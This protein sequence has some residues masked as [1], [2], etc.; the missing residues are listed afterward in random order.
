MQLQREAEWKRSRG[1]RQTIKRCTN[2]WQTHLYLPY[3]VRTGGRRTFSTAAAGMTLL[4]I[5]YRRISE[6][7][8]RTQ[9]VL[10]DSL[11]QYLQIPLLSLCSIIDVDHALYGVSRWPLDF[12][13]EAWQDEYTSE[14]TFAG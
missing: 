12:Q 4:R 8:A 10:R 5:R 14:S 3:L 1:M 2:G 7:I 6:D 11:A 9:C 13:S